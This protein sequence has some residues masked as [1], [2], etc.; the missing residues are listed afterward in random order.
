MLNSEIV[1]DL[2][3]FVLGTVALNAVTI[4]FNKLHFKRPEIW[5]SAI[6]VI[7]YTVYILSRS[8]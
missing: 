3:G 8:L 4:Y 5:A 6:I 7:S 2:F 1:G